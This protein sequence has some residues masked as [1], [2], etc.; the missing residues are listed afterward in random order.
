MHAR[1]LKMRK[2]PAGFSF[3]KLSFKS[4]SDDVLL[5]SS[6]LYLMVIESICIQEYTENQVSCTLTIKTKITI[7]VQN[8]KRIRDTRKPRKE[9]ERGGG[10]RGG[11]GIRRRMRRREERK[12]KEEKSG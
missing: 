9:G 8:K 3:G 10:G 5:L 6:S 7:L 11:G 1:G 4:Y 12:W 2:K